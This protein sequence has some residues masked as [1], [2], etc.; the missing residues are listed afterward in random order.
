MAKFESPKVMINKSAKE[1]YSIL[2]N[3]NNLKNI[4]P[5]NMQQFESTEDSCSFK[6]E[7]MPKIQL[8]IK[9]RIPYSKITLMAKDSQIPFYLD[10]KIIDKNTQCE[11][12]LE[13]NAEIN[14]MMKMMVEKPLTNMLNLLASK[15]QSL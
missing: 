3:L 14:M 10:C 5:P 2:G 13:I 15:M 7:S 8:E 1:L 9:E 12:Q 4:I 11:S 6:M